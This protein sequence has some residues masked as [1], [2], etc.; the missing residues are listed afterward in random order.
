MMLPPAMIALPFKLLLFVLVDGWTLVIQSAG[1]ELQDTGTAHVTVHENGAW[2]A[3]V[4]RRRSACAVPCALSM[5]PPHAPFRRPATSAI[6]SMS[7]PSSTCR[8]DAALPR[9]APRAPRS[10]SPRRS[11]T[12]RSAGDVVRAVADHHRARE[13]RRRTPPPPP[14]RR[15]PCRRPRAVMFTNAVSGMTGD[16]DGGVGEPRVRLGARPRPRP[17]AR[18]AT[19]RARRPPRAT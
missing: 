18:R 3:R 14:A 12:A 5:R 13:R 8:H 9:R 15:A 17:R 7:P 2:Q 19:A 1:A 10:P 6:A 16:T 11:P 4:G